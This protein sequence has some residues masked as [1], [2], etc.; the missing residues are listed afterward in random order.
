MVKIPLTVESKK[1]IFDGKV[2]MEAVNIEMLNKILKTKDEDGILKTYEN[3]GHNDIYENEFVQ[4]VY[5]TERQQLLKFA[6]NIKFKNAFVR[7]D[8]TKDL[9]NYGRVSVYKSLGLFSFRKQI[10]GALAYGIY[11]DID[12]SNCHPSLLLQ[13]AEHNNIKC[14]YLKKYV[15]NRQKYIDLVM[16]TYDCSKD[17]AKTLFIILLYFGSFSRWTNELNIED[18]EEI[19]FITKLKKELKEI[20]Q[21]LTDNN[22]ELAKALQTKRL[23][24]KSKKT[25]IVGGVVSYILQEWECQIIETLYNY[26]TEQKIINNDA[27]LC[28]DGLMIKSNKY[29]DDLLIKFNEIIKNKLGFDLTFVK[30]EL[31]TEIYDKLI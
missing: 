10:R 28:A 8:K 12:I 14:K 11:T 29:N 24:T 4:K 13:I 18:A 2:L 15:N 6:E 31:N 27:V 3:I 9:N 19:E 23:N 5:C 20:G 17:N 25:N 16:N 7:Y 21:I 30:K 1:S 22:K 26:C